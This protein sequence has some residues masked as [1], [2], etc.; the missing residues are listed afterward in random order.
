MAGKRV[1]IRCDADSSSGFGHFSRALSIARCLKK[2]SE[3]VV[4]IGNYNDFA[5]ELLM[6]YG[7]NYVALQQPFSFDAE[8]L[9][10]QAQEFDY[11]LMDSYLADESLMRSLSKGSSKLI[12]IDDFGKFDDYSYLDLLINFTINGDKFPY[13]AK[14]NSLGLKYFPAKPEL[15]TIRISRM[16]EKSVKRKNILVCLS[17]MS[18]YWDAE[19]QLLD[20]LDSV[21]S[22]E[23]IVII[24][25]N[26]D[27]S[28]H[29]KNKN[30]IQK[31]KPQFAVEQLYENSDFVISGGGLMKYEAAYCCIPNATFNLTPDQHSDTVEFEKADL[32]VNLGEAYAPDEKKLK[33]NLELF[34]SSGSSVLQKSSKERFVNRSAENVVREILAV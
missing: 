4:F 27:L 3:E 32:T 11:L 22:R 29:S 10:R 33:S 2:R 21:V 31:V 7:I 16:M 9:L 26:S 18:L 1:L 13:N 23:Q 20:I 25:T 5:I 34:I 12:M 6:A 24:S 19:K 17:S 15:D 30:N 14:N 8:N 28:F